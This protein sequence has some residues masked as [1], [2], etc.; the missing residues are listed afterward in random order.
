M[1]HEQRQRVTPSGQRQRVVIGLHAVVE[2]GGAEITQPWVVEQVAQAA[3]GMPHAVQAG[4]HARGDQAVA[5][6]EEEVAVG[7]DR[8]A[9]QLL[10]ELRNGL[11]QCRISLPARPRVAGLL[12]GLSGR[13]RCN[14]LFHLTQCQWPSCRVWLQVIGHGRQVQMADAFGSGEHEVLAHAVV[15]LLWPVHDPT[16]PRC[17]HGSAPARQIE[18]G[19]V[20]FAALV[21][22][23]AQPFDKA[24]ARQLQRAV[25]FG[26]FQQQ[27]MPTAA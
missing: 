11:Q 14:H 12:R 8:L 5:A 15:G 2:Q 22:K 20:V 13:R 23:V 7:F 19:L 4:D 3:A 1:E 25:A 10:P 17:L 6:A 26:G 16:E 18:H 24:D 27:Q 21:F 9:E